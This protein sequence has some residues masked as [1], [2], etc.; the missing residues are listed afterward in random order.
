[1]LA[2]FPSNISSARKDTASSQFQE[3]VEKGLNKCSDVKAVSYGWGIENDFPVRG[4]E[5]G[6]IG[7]I[8]IAFIG[9]PSI[10]AHM[11]F[12]ETAAFKE[13]VDLITGMV[14]MSKLAMFHISCRDLAKM[15]E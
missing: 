11:K 14:G 2:Y 7:S 1:M 5:E 13:N 3:F 6:Q 4:E 10:D 9:W 15:T 8:L 12:R